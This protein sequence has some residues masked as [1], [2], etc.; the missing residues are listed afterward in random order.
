MIT[1]SEATNYDLQGHPTAEYSW[2]DG[3]VKL[4]PYFILEICLERVR[5]SSEKIV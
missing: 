4:F 5:F 1:V 3:Y 2:F